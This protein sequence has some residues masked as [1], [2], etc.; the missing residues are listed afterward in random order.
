MA[1]CPSCGAEVSDFGVFCPHCGGDLQSPPPR[2]AAPACEPARPT[3]RACVRQPG[4]F[5]VTFQGRSPRA[6]FWIQFA[7]IAGVFASLGMLIAVILIGRALLMTAPLGGPVDQQALSREL[8]GTAA[9]SVLVI[10]PFN[11]IANIFTLPMFVR[12]WHDLGFSGWTVLLFYALNLVPVVGGLFQVA[13]FL[14]LGI[15]PGSPDA[16]RFGPP[17][18]ACA[19]DAEPAGEN[20][21]ALWSLFWILE[22]VRVVY[23]VYSL[24]P[25][26]NPNGN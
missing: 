5:S 15:V 3:T 20:P 4:I 11:L 25:L 2:R 22:T 26:L 10:L 17:C 8:L 19:S 23:V 21:V 16:N 6:K 7:V 1:N 12:R 14:V 9:V 18:N 13:Q 24:I